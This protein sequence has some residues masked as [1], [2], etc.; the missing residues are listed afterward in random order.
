M[1]KVK[2]HLWRTLSLP[3]LTTCLKLHHLGIIKC[4]STEKSNC[5]FISKLGW[6]WHIIIIC[7]DI[8]TTGKTKK[9]SIYIYLWDTFSLKLMVPYALSSYRKFFSQTKHS[10][11]LK[12][13]C[14]EVIKW[15]FLRVWNYSNFVYSLLFL[16]FTL[17]KATIPW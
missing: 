2:H 4:L 14:L 1:F 17:K 7:N 16:V 13:E 8:L 12:E 10:Y 15:E 5:Y 3:E 11:I 9:Y 6:S